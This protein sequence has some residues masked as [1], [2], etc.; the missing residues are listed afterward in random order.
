MQDN[1][2]YLQS[3]AT[4]DEPEA[5]A[6]KKKGWILG[7]VIGVFMILAIVLV[8]L[9]LVT[10]AQSEI[11]E[12]KETQEPLPDDEVASLQEIY[13]DFGIDEKLNSEY[14]EAVKDTEYSDYETD[15]EVATKYADN[16]AKDV[17]SDY[18]DYC[19]DGFKTLGDDKKVSALNSK[20][21]DYYLD[22]GHIVVM[23]ADYEVADD[24]VGPYTTIIYGRGRSGLYSTFDT[25]STEL[26]VYMSKAQLFNDV[27]GVPTFYAVK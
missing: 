21:L 3:I 17:C 22:N 25:G 18:S 8:V 1:I 27:V 13:D 20:S 14:A 11:A 19:L 15:L 5:P 7:L 10:P 26:S 24:I 4:V 6:P 2:D 23:V 12:D 9:S 16:S